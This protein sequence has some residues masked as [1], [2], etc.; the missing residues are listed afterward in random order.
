MGRGGLGGEGFVSVRPGD[1]RRVG[2]FAG[3]QTREISKG[4]RGRREDRE[5]PIGGHWRVRAIH[6][7]CSSGSSGAGPRLD[8]QLP[9]R[10]RNLGC[11]QVELKPNSPSGTTG[12]SPTRPPAW[13]VRNHTAGGLGHLPKQKTFPP[14]TPWA[15]EPLRSPG[16]SPV[17]GRKRHPGAEGCAAQAAS[18]AGRRRRCPRRGTEAGRHR[19][20]GSGGGGPGRCQQGGRG[21]RSCCAARALCPSPDP[22]KQLLLLPLE[23]RAAGRR[24][25][26]EGGDTRLGR[27][28]GRDGW[29]ESGRRG[30][31]HPDRSGGRERGAHEPLRGAHHKGSGRRDARWSDGSRAP[32]PLPSP[33]S[34]FAPFPRALPPTAQAG[35]TQARQPPGLLRSAEVAEPGERPRQLSAPPA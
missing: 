18:R 8:R 25:E 27:R 9:G 33:L 29:G 16:Y 7:C 30:D 26:E 5:D 13:R 22:L 23:G 31:E 6:P 28:E 19:G 24:G 35:V 12:Q 34:P 2:E 21:S 11:R 17:L 4:K 32:S 3:G 15:P 10:E 14:R 20:G 1:E